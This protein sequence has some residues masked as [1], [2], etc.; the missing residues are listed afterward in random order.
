MSR[1]R[2][3]G[4]RHTQQLSRISLTAGSRALARVASSPELSL[5]EADHRDL[6]VSRHMT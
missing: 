4:W 6:I 3:N 1:W 5:R 2:Y